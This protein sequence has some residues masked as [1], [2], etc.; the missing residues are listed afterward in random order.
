[1]RKPRE[2]DP[3][4]CHSAAGDRCVG[5]FLLP[6]VPQQTRRFCG[7]S[8]WHFELGQCGAAL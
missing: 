7:Q 4:G 2:I 1:M 3:V 6:E 8:V 5:T